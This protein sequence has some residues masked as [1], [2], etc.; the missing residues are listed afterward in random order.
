[1][2][3]IKVWAFARAA[4][5]MLL[6]A[7]WSNAQVPECSG[8]IG[9]G[10][11]IRCALRA[12]LSAAVERGA[13][14]AAQAREVAGSPLLP[15]N[16]VLSAT[17]G[18]RSIPGGVS[19]YNWYASLSQEL[20]IAGQRGARR[21][22]A[23]SEVSAHA[24]R[25]VLS[26]RNVAVEAWVRYFEA[27][28]A[29]EQLALAL[30]LTAASEA[31]ATV[32]GAKAESGILAPVDAD[33]TDALLARALQAK[34]AAE[35]RALV[36]TAALASLLG[37]DP[38]TAAAA[39]DGELVPL[40]VDRIAKLAPAGITQ[41]PEI[42]AADSERRAQLQRAE[43][44]RRARVPNPTLSAFVEN[45]G[46]NERVF[47]AG[48]A[49]PIPLPGNV[50]RTYAGE[51]AEA[52]ALASRAGSERRLIERGVRLELVSARQAYQS[53]SRELAVFTP[54]KLARA[55]QTLDDLRGQVEAGRLPVRD[56]IVAQQTLIDFIEAGLAA[57][58]ELCLASVE[59]ARAAGF[60]LESRLP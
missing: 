26:Q 1:V 29:R 54:E 53:R 41:R 10:D 34:F 11:V 12:S 32:V 43:G 23:Q 13:L 38:A 16:P 6:C 7:S 39:I 36:A 21:G 31:L 18:R 14:T 22:A 30:R 58:L 50:G 56:A 59:L 8:S 44:Y 2:I 45:D 42:Q 20:E 28:A 47:G 40:N 17:V 55:A 48:L 25:L 27:I 46:L 33:V 37:R 24:A 5:A 57:R 3:S 9:R 52:E 15:S 4:T 35:R 51:I 60:P 49:L 19:T